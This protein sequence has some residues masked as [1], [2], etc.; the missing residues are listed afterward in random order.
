MVEL[1]ELLG[2]RNGFVG[3]LCGLIVR[4]AQRHFKQEELRL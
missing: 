3:D 2:Y 1:Q 4:L